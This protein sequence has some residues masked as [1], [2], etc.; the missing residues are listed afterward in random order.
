MSAT[1][2]RL[3]A[4]HR[5]LLRMGPENTRRIQSQAKALRAALLVAPE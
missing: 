4:L 2:E 1:L 3:P 5:Q